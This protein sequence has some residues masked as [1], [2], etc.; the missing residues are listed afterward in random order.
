MDPDGTLHVTPPGGRTRTTRPS[1]LA[2]ACTRQ[3]VTD[4]LGRTPTRYRSPTPK[5][6]ADRRAAAAERARLAA[7]IEAELDAA[8]AMRWHDAAAGSQD[9]DPPPF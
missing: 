6:R 9:G 1:C 4:L 2:E 5:E 8:L 3:A 7:E